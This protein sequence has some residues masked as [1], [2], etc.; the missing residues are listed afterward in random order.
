MIKTL[1]TCS[2]AL[3]LTGS[4]FAQAL[5][6]PDKKGNYALNLG[7]TESKVTFGG[8]LWK[9]NVT[10]LPVRESADLKSKILFYLK[11]GETIPAFIGMGGSDE[12]LKNAVDKQGRTWMRVLLPAKYGQGKDAYVRANSRYIRPVLPA[13][14]K[15][16]T[17]VF[18][19]EAGDEPIDGVAVKPAQT[20]A[21]GTQVNININLGGSGKS[22]GAKGE[23]P[24][25]ARPGVPGAKAA[26]AAPVVGGVGVQF[27]PGWSNSTKDGVM[28]SVSPDG[29]GRVVI[30]KVTG[31]GADGPWDD[32]QAKMATHLGPHF[33]GMTELTEVNTEHD[34]FRDGVGLRVVTYTAK[35]DGAAI[36]LVVDFARENN[37]DGGGLVLIARS[38]RKG[39]TAT[40]A[41]AKKVAESL[42]LKK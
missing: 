29:K 38:S 1:V 40:Q 28:Y 31:L 26:P 36:D 32:V 4:L 20:N 41:A 22:A 11:K 5:P 23:P 35:M 27:A 19:D 7:P 17:P 9:C 42:R 37:V 39:D 14:V 10:K 25:P 33:P 30:K 24:P 21:G 6:R 15:D 8:T 34:V 18:A 12:V 3:A 13:A 2:L 16:T